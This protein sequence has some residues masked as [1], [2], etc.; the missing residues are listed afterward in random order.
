MSDEKLR[1]KT[2]RNKEIGGKTHEGKKKQDIQD[3]NTI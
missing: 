1:M 2:K 3:I